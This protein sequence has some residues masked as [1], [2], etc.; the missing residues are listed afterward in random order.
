MVK[1]SAVAAAALLLSLQHAAAQQQHLENTSQVLETPF[2]GQHVGLAT[3]DVN[4]DGLTDLYFTGN[5]VNDKLHL[6]KGNFVFEDITERAGIFQKGWSTGVTVT[7][8]I[9]MVYWIS[10]FVKQ[11]MNLPKI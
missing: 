5:Q 3:F 8:I 7:D 2:L 6:N 9:M 10:M 11:E 4:N 1:S